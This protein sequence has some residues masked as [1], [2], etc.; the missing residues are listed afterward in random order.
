[1]LITGALALSLA[2]EYHFMLS[3]QSIIVR[4]FAGIIV[5]L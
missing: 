2:K 5:K 1:M 3:F 4:I